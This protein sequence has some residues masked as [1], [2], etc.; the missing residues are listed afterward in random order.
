MII[1]HDDFFYSL[2]RLQQFILKCWRLQCIVVLYSKM[3][4]AQETVLSVQEN[5][6]LSQKV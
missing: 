6:N 5:V 1:M 4:Q 3:L 2:S